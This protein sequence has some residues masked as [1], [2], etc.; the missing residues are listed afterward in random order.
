LGILYKQGNELFPETEKVSWLER[1]MLP[2]L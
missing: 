2:I 1:S